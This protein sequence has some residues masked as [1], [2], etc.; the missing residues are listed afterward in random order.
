MAFRSLLHGYKRQSM[1]IRR[2][3]REVKSVQTSAHEALLLPETRV[4]PVWPSFIWTLGETVR[5][6]TKEPK[7]CSSEVVTRLRSQRSTSV[8]EGGGENTG[9][10]P[11]LCFFWLQVPGIPQELTHSI[12]QLRKACLPLYHLDSSSSKMARE[13][14]KW[15][16]SRVF[17]HSI[18]LHAQKDNWCY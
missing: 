18:A 4:C 7:E 2:L 3:S 17:F 13:K 9:W 8:R 15:Q 6:P 14:K 12:S 10:L 1:S 5:I 16:G 11:K